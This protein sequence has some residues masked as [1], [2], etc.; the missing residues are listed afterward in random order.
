GA[1]P[2]TFR[3]EARAA[4]GRGEPGTRGLQRC[5]LE[6]RAAADRL[7][8][9]RFDDEFLAAIDEAEARFVRA[10]EGGFHLCLRWRGLP[11]PHGVRQREGRHDER[12]V[13]AGISDMRAPEDL[14]PVLCDTLAFDLADRL[15]DKCAANTR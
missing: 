15:L 8:R 12:R 2:L 13:S 6:A 5:L 1:M 9:H 7:D 14:D 3:E 10:F 11:A 4:C